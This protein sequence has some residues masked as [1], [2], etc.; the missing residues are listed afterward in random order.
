MP[1]FYDDTRFIPFKHKG[2]DYELEDHDRKAIDGIR[3][4]LRKGNFSERT[5]VLDCIQ[6]LENL[7]KK[8]EEILRNELAHGND[9]WTLKVIHEEIIEL[10]QKLKEEYKKL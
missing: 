3:S 8:I 9:N 4:R 10:F 7:N 6:F 2:Q 1:G 5:E